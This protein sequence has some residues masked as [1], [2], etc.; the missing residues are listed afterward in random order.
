MEFDIPIE[1]RDIGVICLRTRSQEFEDIMMGLHSF[2][3]EF[4]ESNLF[5]ES[6]RGCYERQVVCGVAFDL[7]FV[8]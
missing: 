5:G 2:L 6:P 1:K 3:D 7:F 4:T 8:V